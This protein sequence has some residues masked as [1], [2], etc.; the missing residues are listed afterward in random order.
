MTAGDAVGLSRIHSERRGGEGEIAGEMNEDLGKKRVAC[1]GRREYFDEM[2][3]TREVSVNADRL[4]T[5]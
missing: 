4:D 2:W 1:T 5:S 3:R